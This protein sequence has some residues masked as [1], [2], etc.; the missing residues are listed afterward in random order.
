MVDGAVDSRITSAESRWAS[1]AQYFRM[2]LR[3]GAKEQCFGATLSAAN[4]GVL[5]PPA[6]LPDEVLGPGS[7][8]VKIDKR[9]AWERLTAG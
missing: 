1:K 2:D 3:V 6:N 9:H 8:K 7:A 4:V 5:R